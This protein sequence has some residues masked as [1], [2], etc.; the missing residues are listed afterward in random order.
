MTHARRDLP[1][2]FEIPTRSY[3]RTQEKIN[4]YSRYV[5]EG[6]DTKNIHTDE[7]VAKKA[8]LPGPVA[9]GRYPIAFISEALLRFFGEGWICGGSLDVAL[10]KPIFPGDTIT[11]KGLLKEKKQEGEALRIV[12]EVWLENQHGEKATIGTASGLV[13]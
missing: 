12:L 11:V 13:R 9:Q 10:A 5:F 2:G 7:E 3:L 4:A 6:K 1:I 8:G